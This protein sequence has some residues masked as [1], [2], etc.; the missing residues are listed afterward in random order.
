MGQSEFGRKVL[1]RSKVGVGVPLKVSGAGHYVPSVAPFRKV[2]GKSEMS[3][4]RPV[5]VFEWN[6]CTE[7]PRFPNGD[8][9]SPSAENGLFQ[10][11]FPCPL[12]ECKAFALGD[13]AD[14]RLPS[15]EKIIAKVG[16]NFGCASTP[17]PQSVLA[18]YFIGARG[19]DKCCE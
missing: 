6:I 14:S 15:S 12:S 1:T 13:A 10:F 8:L 4:T 18:V 16:A 9:R 17:Q 5:S 2:R 19:F 7:R 3:P 11:Y